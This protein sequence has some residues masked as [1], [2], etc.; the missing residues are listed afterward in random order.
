MHLPVA[1][2]LILSRY[3]QTSACCL[4]K[5]V[6]DEEIRVSS[7]VDSGCHSE[8]AKKSAFH[9]KFI[10]CLVQIPPRHPRPAIPVRCGCE[11]LG[12]GQSKHAA[13]TGRVSGPGQR[14]CS[15]Y[16]SA[17]RDVVQLTKPSDH[18]ALALIAFTP[19]SSGQSVTFIHVTDSLNVFRIEKRIIPCDEKRKKRSARNIENCR[20]GH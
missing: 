7:C 5:A 19:E 9:S 12:G 14:L 10:F 6:T 18:H 20:Y 4:L 16:H 15:G 1:K 11:S 2:P 13:H 3:S 17:N 8:L